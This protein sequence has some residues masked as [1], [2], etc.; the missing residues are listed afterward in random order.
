MRD[1]VIHDVDSLLFK[2]FFCGKK[3]H[4]SHQILREKKF[5]EFTQLDHKVPLNIIIL[6]F[7]V[8]YSQIWLIAIVGDGYY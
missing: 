8:T 1:Y 3:K 6:L 4:Q 7:S 2:G 5:R